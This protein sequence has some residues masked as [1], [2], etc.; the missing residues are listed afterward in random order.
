VRIRRYLPAD[1]AAVIALFREFMH[2]LIPPHLGAEFRSYIE[3]AIHEELGRI[4]EYYLLRPDQGFWVAEAQGDGALAGMVGVERHDADSAELRRM[5][6]AKAHRRTGIGRALL[7]MAESFCRQ[8][9]YRRIVL[10]TSELQ[11]AAARL[12]ESS[13]YRLLSE[14][15]APQASHKTVGAGLTR[16]HYE[17]RLE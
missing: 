14:E 5:A 13:G 9:A 10:S 16:Y 3:R 6:V 12:Y 11:L 1:Q 15:K 7:S 4:E 17:K 8:C 2:E